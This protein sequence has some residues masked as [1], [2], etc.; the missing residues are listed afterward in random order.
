MLLK[1]TQ[2]CQWRCSQYRNVAIAP[3]LPALEPMFPTPRSWITNP[4]R[5]MFCKTGYHV[6]GC[7]LPLICYFWSGCSPACLFRMETVSF[8]L[9][10]Q[11]ASAFP[12]CLF[13]QS[14]AKLILAALSNHALGPHFGSNYYWTSQLI[15][16]DKSILPWGHLKDILSVAHR[17]LYVV[18][19]TQD[20]FLRAG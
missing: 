2:N 3:L 11:D 1:S 8:L 14:R 9:L 16:L 19:A 5:R 20:F 10:K 18:N 12:T 13:L 6:R 17:T 7:L 4:Y 15:R